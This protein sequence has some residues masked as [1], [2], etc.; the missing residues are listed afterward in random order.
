MTVVRVAWI[1]PICQQPGKRTREHVFGRW[2]ADLLGV[3]NQ[4]V[5][6]HSSRGGA[7]WSSRGIEVVVTVC[8]SCN[9]GWM[10]DLES[11]FAATFSDVILGRAAVLDAAA[12]TTLAHWATKTALMLEPQLRGTGNQTHRPRGH[13]AQL[14]AGPPPGSRVW[15]GA[16]APRTRLVFWQ[17][18][19]M[20][21]AGKPLR[22]DSPRIGYATLMTVG[23]LLIVVLVM[24]RD[25]GDEFE[26]EGM[27]RAAFRS[28]WPLPEE[29]IRWPD[30]LILNDNGIATFWP[31]RAGGLVTRG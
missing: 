14:P 29:A 25:L 30:G 9:Q 27:P 2:L 31:P 19:P 18:V 6:A 12:L 22:D 10:S 20:S 4:R 23:S 11:E 7:L 13:P 8:A 5:T 21:P 26:A 17:G 28:V 1:C 24:D 3:R 15:L 16:Y